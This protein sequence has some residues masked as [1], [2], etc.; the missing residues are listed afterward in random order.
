MLFPEVYDVNNV[1]C[2]D[3]DSAPCISI[4]TFSSFSKNTA[5][6][7]YIGNPPPE[8]LRFSD[9]NDLRFQSLICDTSILA[10]LNQNAVCHY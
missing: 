4:L 8:F 10:W 7:R 6:N 2:V 5:R 9:G 3:F 1:L